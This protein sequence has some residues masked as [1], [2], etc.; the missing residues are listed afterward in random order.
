ML[1]LVYID[2]L[3]GEGQEY[4]LSTEEFVSLYLDLVQKGF[5]T[6]HDEKVMLGEEFDRKAIDYDLLSETLQH[7]NREIL[8]LKLTEDQVIEKIIATLDEFEAFENFLQQKVAETSLFMQFSTTARKDFLDEMNKVLG[9][10][11]K[12]L[13]ELEDM[14]KG[15]VERDA[16]NLNRVVD[17]KV[18]GRLLKSFGG[19]RKLALSSSSTVQII[20]AE[21]AFFRFRKGR[22]TPPKHGVIYEIPDIYKASS[23]ISGKIARAYANAIVKAARADLVGSRSN[24]DLTLKKRLDEIRGQAVKK[25]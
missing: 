22:G 15:Y 20:G 19:L 6:Y 25:D 7:T 14:L 16:P 2:R 12:F 4:K 21:K 23:K 13:K 9:E 8:A 3:V 10:V 5:S 11:R 18:A 1:H 24:A 17:Y